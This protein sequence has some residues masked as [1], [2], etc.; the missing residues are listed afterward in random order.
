[1]PPPLQPGNTTA[2]DVV[3]GQYPSRAESEAAY[4]AHIVVVVVV[5]V[6]VDRT[7]PPLAPTHKCCQSDLTHEPKT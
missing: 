4:W 5:L 1:M 2:S 7:H 3:S 6:T